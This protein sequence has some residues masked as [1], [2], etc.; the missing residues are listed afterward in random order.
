MVECWTWSGEFEVWSGILRT[1]WVPVGC[2]LPYYMHLSNSL[3]WSGENVPMGIVLDAFPTLMA[4]KVTISLIF[5]E[6]LCVVVYGL[7]IESPMGLLKKNIFFSVW[8]DS[9]IEVCWPISSLVSLH[10]NVSLNFWQNDPLIVENRTAK[11]QTAI[12]FELIYLF[13]S[14]KCL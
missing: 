3:S 2:F 13:T 9:P 11:S 12:M 5:W 8:V 6:L 10:S 4:S 7:F 1:Y 14:K